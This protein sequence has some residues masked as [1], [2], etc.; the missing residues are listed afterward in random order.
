MFNVVDVTKRLLLSC[1]LLISWQAI[2]DIP[3]S[4]DYAYQRFPGSQIVEYRLENN[5]VYALALGRMQRAAG[6]VAPSQS[7]RFQGD[8][9]RITYE[10]PDGFNGQEVF[11]HFRGQLLTQAA[12]AV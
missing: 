9:R 5:T 1:L 10:I 8:L 6:R 3:G 4:S 12:R 2:A 11:E 7:E